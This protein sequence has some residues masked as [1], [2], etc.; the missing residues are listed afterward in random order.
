MGQR[1]SFWRGRLAAMSTLEHSRPLDVQDDSEEVLFT[2]PEVAVALRVS[3]STVRRL[4]A[5]GELGV[6]RIGRSV[7]VPSAVLESFAAESM[8]GRFI[9]RRF[10]SSD[11]HPHSRGAS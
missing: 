6:M 3:R 9:P 4:I 11:F 7:R 1:A 5:D 2:I 8:R 10:G